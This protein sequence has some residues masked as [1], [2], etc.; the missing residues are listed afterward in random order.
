VRKVITVS[1][2]GNAFQLEDDAYGVLATYLDE[3]LQAL[4]TNPD[5]AEI[6]ADL[7]QAIADKCAAFLNPHKGVVS[8]SEI[9]SVIAQMGPVDSDAAGSPGAASAGTSSHTDNAHQPGAAAP[10]RL[11]QISEGALVSGICNGYAAYSG[12]DVTWIRVIFVL[13]IL[14]TGG[15]GLLAYLVL[16][17]IIPFA[18]TSE[19]RAAAHGIPFNARLLVEQA[20]RHYAQFAS[21]AHRQAPD[22]SWRNEWRRA[23]AEWRL[24]RRRARQQWRE[25][26]RYGRGFG[27]RAPPPAA[28]MA[29]PAPASYVGHVISGS[30][31][32]IMGLVLAALGIVLMLAVISLINHRAVF[33]WPLP[34]DIPLWAGLIG[35]FVVYNFIA[36]P[37]KAVRHSAWWYAGNYRGPWLGAW[38]AVVGLAV[39]VVVVWYGLHHMPQI[40]EFF[41]HL[42]RLWQDSS[43][44]QTAARLSLKA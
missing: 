28:A 17:F 3:S 18:N 43:W 22:K 1:L 4:A 30:L 5:Q 35:L 31:L 16:M 6:M 29:A 37:I 36:W 23:R 8:R 7:E 40:Q 15:G 38:D 2:N 20:K 27:F 34:H 24:E 9:D 33:G 32:A 41:E 11:Y 39:A 13:L 26:R 44:S 42:P 19:E 21:G 10:R 12:L 25:Y 14:V